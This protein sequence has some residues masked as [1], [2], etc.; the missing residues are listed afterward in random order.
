MEHAI[1]WFEI[2]AANFQRATKFYNTVLNAQM[3]TTKMGDSELAF[4]P[5]EQQGVGGA[6]AKQPGHQPGPNGPL[7]YLNVTG[8]FDEV[9][10]RI[11]PAGGK[12]I[13]PKTLVTDEIGYIAV[14]VDTE[15][16]HVAL[17]AEKKA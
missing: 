8:R 4:L 17:H 7:I 6:I 5:R 1:N 3:Q 11:E 14:F 12:V 16:N 13:Q 2:P 10:A 9:M 15:G